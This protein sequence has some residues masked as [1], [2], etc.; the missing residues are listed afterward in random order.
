MGGSTLLFFIGQH[1]EAKRF[2]KRINYQIRVKE[3]QQESFYC[4]GSDLL[5]P[6]KFLEQY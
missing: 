3:V 6:N 1:I 2:L 5:L 4:R